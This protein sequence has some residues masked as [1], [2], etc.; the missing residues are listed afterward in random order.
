MTT[1]LT[2]I[3]TREELRAH[4]VEHRIA[5]DVATSRE[6]NMRNL[7]RLIER[8]PSATFGVEPDRAWTFAELL[9]LMAQRCGVSPDE[10]YLEGVDRIDPE[11][12]IDALDL[13]ASRLREAVERGA[14]VLVA[15]G[16][17]TGVL[18]IHLEIARA[19]A[20]AG[21]PVLM[22]ATG[23]SYEIMRYGRGERRE[24][25]YVGGVAMLSDR[26]E[27]KHTHSPRPMRAMLEEL[28]TD[29]GPAALPGLVVGDH[30]WA[31]AAGQAGVE[32]VGFA[33]C[34]DPALFL[35]EAEGKVAVS[36]PLDDNVAPHLYAPLTAYLLAAAGLAG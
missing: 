15:T 6:N 19:L 4:L 21:S 3:P 2:R 9:A 8:D 5:G 22:P 12:T 29:G 1:A 18:A 33:D 14:S 25:R 24:I 26:G 23:W 17:P 32:A 34:N 30:G 11:R 28:M 31:G 36:V 20:A 10:A 27:L 35:A 7:R 16:H 13:M